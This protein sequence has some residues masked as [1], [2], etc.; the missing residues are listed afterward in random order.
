M[1]ALQIKD[2]N[3]SNVP[4][5]VAFLPSA[6]NAASQIITDPISGAKATIAQFHNADNQAL[7]GTANGLLTG[8]VAQLL[9]SSG[10]VNRQRETYGDVAPNTGIA[11]GT[12]QV[13]WPVSLGTV[14]TGAITGTLVNAQS[15]IVPAVTGATNGVA[16]Q[17]NV[18]QSVTLDPNTLSQESFTITA[19]NTAT[20]T[21]TGVITK[22]HNAA[23]PAISF[24]YDQARSG[25]I[26]DGSTG[27]GF[28]AGAT[29]LFNSSLNSLNGGWEATRSAAGELD[30]AN[31]RG[32]AVAAEY[33]NN[34]GG[35]PLVNGQAS[36]LQFD[37][38]RNIQGKGY[39]TATITAP[40]AA[41]T[42]IVVTTP[43]QVNLLQP[44]SPIF[45]LSSGQIVEV[46]Y[47]SVQYVPGTS[48]VA[49]QNPVVTGG[50]TT[51]AFDTYVAAGPGLAGFL[52]S[53]VELSEECL[54][55]PVTGKYYLE[56]AAS[57]DAMPVNN[58]VAENGVLFNGSTMDRMRSAVSD[59]LP[60]TG[61]AAE[62]AMIWNGT[63]FDRL[64]EATGDALTSVGIPSEAPALFNGASFDRQRGN[65]DTTALITHTAS[66]TGSS[67]GDQLNI[68][69]RGLQIGV[70]ITAATGTTPTI[71][72]IV[73]GKDAASGSYYPLFAPAA[74]TAAAGFTLLSVYPG[75]TA[76]STVG[77]QILP[78]TWRVRTVIG[79]T[80]P[81]ITATVGASVI[82]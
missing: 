36:G 38:G 7:A 39:A 43:A 18:G 14:T 56:R 70:N 1:A 78:R 51:I 30:G 48:P 45:F 24:F 11:T 67:G 15:I 69:G 57:Q 64:R 76:S 65:V 55:D 58:I 21:I 2:A 61:I 47:S 73:E 49:L 5:E 3:G 26:A 13:A 77:N 59:A 32:T 28:S 53:G 75:L 20:R 34:G 27:Q 60:T 22:N 68:N 42:S 9:N 46:A 25:M 40:A 74:L 71:Q 41:A 50:E 19:L 17:L 82:I 4:M 66:T 29:Y 62:A 8:G 54:W 52:P 10:N 72:I 16:W 31:G 79:G 6:T 63:T 12:Q 37:R 80:T 35:P 23:A 81:A 33:E 44:G